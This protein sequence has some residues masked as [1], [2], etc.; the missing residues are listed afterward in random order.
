MWGN[1]GVG[2]LRLQVVQIAD[3][4][5]AIP[6]SLTT[7]D[8]PTPDAARLSKTCGKFPELLPAIE[9]PS[10]IP[11]RRGSDFGR[12]ASAKGAAMN[13]ASAQGAGGIEV[14]W[15]AELLR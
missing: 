9:W 15:I 4:L 13:L 14:S 11:S 8:G 10:V 2:D 6:N 1:C 5:L 3:A 7:D 12:G